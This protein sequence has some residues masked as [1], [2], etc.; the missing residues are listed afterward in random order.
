M[1]ASWDAMHPVWRAF[2]QHQDEDDMSILHAVVAPWPSLHARIDGKLIAARMS[3]F[4]PGTARWID[5]QMQATN[6][7]RS[8][9]VMFQT[10]VIGARIF[11]RTFLPRAPSS[12]VLRAV[13]FVP[14]S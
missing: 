3:G 4:T 12:A 6:Q 14:E 13:V 5:T 11:A 1:Q 2:Q 10:H 7:A 8:S 9:K